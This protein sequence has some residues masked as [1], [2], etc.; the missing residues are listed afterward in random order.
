MCVDVCGLRKTE[1]ITEQDA[2]L[3][4]VASI[5]GRSDIYVESDALL[6]IALCLL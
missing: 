2:D 1:T 5:V 3:A 4:V 6:Y